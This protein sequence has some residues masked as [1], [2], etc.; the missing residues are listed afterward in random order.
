MTIEAALALVSVL[1]TVVLC[2]GALL[3]ASTQE[4]GEIAAGHT[5]DPTSL[6]AAANVDLDA[7]RSIAD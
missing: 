3:A 6:A 5:W 7:A 1:A 4:A 2:L